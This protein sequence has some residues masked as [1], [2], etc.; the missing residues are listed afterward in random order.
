MKHLLK[1]IAYLAGGAVIL[2]VWFLFYLLLA[3]VSVAIG[4][5]K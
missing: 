3:L 4:W 1:G 5:G 2:L